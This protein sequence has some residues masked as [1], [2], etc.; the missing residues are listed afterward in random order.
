MTVAVMVV[1]LTIVAVLVRKIYA[2]CPN[3]FIYQSPPVTPGH[4]SGDHE[5]FVCELKNGCPVKTGWRHRLQ[6]LLMFC[7]PRSGLVLFSVEPPHPQ[8]RWIF[9]RSATCTICSPR[10]LHQT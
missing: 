5:K 4:G 8:V 10:D 3:L 6:R 1:V 2:D 7:W 9:Y